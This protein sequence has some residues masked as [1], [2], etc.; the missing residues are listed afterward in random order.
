MRIVTFSECAARVESRLDRFAAEGLLPHDFGGIVALLFGQDLFGVL[1]RLRTLSLASANPARQVRTGG[2]DTLAG[3]TFAFCKRTLVWD[4][5]RRA[6]DENER[7][8]SKQS[9]DVH[10]GTPS[11]NG[12]PST[13]T[14]RAALLPTQ[15][16]EC[17]WVPSNA[18]LV[19]TVNR[20][21]Q[22][23]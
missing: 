22:R 7:A 11:G 8:R 20:P 4:E 12:D 15:Q 1:F 19:Q 5:R 10:G 18:S 14:L 16:Q 23:L 21:S 2:R 17:G 3:D 9:G 6:A 13:T